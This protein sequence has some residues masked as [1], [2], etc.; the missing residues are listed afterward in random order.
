MPY[1]VEKYACKCLKVTEFFRTFALVYMYHYEALFTIF[2]IN[3][4]L[5]RRSAAACR[6]FFWM[7]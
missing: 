7:D 1:I 2:R 5:F 3:R 4:S 6:L